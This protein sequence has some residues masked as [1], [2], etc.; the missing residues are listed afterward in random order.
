MVE[1]QDFPTALADE[2][3]AA[4]LRWTAGVVALT[5][6]ALALF[7]AGAIAAWTEDLVPGP[8]T[9]RAVIAAEHWKD[10]TARIGLGTPYTALHHLWKRSE[11]ARWPTLTT[12]STSAAESSATPPRF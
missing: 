6:L 9:T 5:A 1:E 12:A 2:A 10:T 3:D 7:N 4:P 8:G 11:S